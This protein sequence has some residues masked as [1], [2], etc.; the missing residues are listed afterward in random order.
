MVNKKVWQQNKDYKQVRDARWD[1]DEK[2]KN[3]TRFDIILFIV[4]NYFFRCKKAQAAARTKM[5]KNYQ[6]RK[7]TSSEG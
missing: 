6:Q 5:I 1:R 7:F 2:R 4:N 3:M